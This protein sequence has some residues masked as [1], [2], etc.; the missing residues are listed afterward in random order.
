VEVEERRGEERQLCDREEGVLR[1]DDN[2]RQ[3]STARPRKFGDFARI[4]D[5]LEKIKA[6]RVRVFPQGGLYGVTVRIEV[7]C[8]IAGGEICS[9]WREDERRGRKDLSRHRKDDLMG[10]CLV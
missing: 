9:R 3:G 7:G 4:R 8:W 5:L 6:T 10:A 1:V 2:R